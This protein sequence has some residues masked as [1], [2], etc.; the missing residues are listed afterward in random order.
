MGNTDEESKIYI[1]GSEFD[2]AKIHEYMDPDALKSLS[3]KQK[4]AIEKAVLDAL[5]YYK[6]LEEE[7]ELND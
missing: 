2:K 6:G 7:R 1:Y 5:N 4:A 3:P